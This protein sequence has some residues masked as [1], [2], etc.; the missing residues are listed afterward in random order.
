MKER[1][2]NFLNKNIF[3]KIC[4]KYLLKEIKYDL[5]RVE[6][7]CEQVPIV[8]CKITEGKLSR[9]DYSAETI[10]TEYEENLYTKYIEKE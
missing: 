10:I 2:Y 9:P 6:Y 8:Y 5:E 7:I 4:S 3:R 1:I